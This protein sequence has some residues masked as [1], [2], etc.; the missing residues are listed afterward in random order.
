MRH[1]YYFLRRAPLVGSDILQ[2][3]V[4][5]LTKSAIYSAPSGVSSQPVRSNV[6]ILGKHRR[7]LQIARQ[8][9]SPIKEWAKC[10][11]CRQL[12]IRIVCNNKYVT[13]KN[14]IPNTSY[15][16]W[17]LSNRSEG[18]IGK[19]FYVGDFIVHKY[20]LFVHRD[21]VRWPV[22][23]LI[24]MSKIKLIRLNSNRLPHIK[25]SSM[26][27]SVVYLPVLGSSIMWYL[28]AFV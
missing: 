12:F 24:K 28:I 5:T 16:L 14:F 2:K 27:S 3:R 1:Y 10:K 15:S 17:Y 8:P 4:R 7:D 20:A 9:A 22:I 21:F 19:Y 26:V 6:R 23:R 18:S 13:N 11:C 25:D